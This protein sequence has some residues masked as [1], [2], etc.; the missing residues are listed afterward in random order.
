MAHDSEIIKEEDIQLN[1]EE[2]FAISRLLES[3]HA[4]F[5]QLWE[6]GKP[7]FTKS[8]PNSHN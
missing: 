5:Y 7:Y 8:I 1:Y 3:H 6:L 2:F 4:V